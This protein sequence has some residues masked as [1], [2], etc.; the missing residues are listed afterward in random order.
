MVYPTD[1]G[2]S[3][4]YDYRSTRGDCLIVADCSYIPECDFYKDKLD[5]LPMTAEFIK[6]M[7]CHKESKDCA[8]HFSKS[9]VPED[10]TAQDFSKF[11][12]F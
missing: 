1:T 6:M 12:D 9:T 3:I 10:M 4:Q 7:Y 2:Q 5:V 8:K 11:D